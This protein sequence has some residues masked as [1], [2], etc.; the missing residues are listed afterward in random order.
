MTLKS[1]NV[2]HN[3]L[4]IVIAVGCATVPAD[5]QT[6]QIPPRS[7]LATADAIWSRLDTPS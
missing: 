5:A 4:M 7:T 3:I 6:I 2:T 1:S